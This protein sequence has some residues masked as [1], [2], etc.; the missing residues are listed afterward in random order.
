[1]NR[2]RLGTFVMLVGAL[3]SCAPCTPL[4]SPC[5]RVIVR[6]GDTNAPITSAVASITFADGTSHVL[7]SCAQ[8]GVGLSFGPNCY[9]VLGYGCTGTF[10]LRVRHSSFADFE[11]RVTAPPGRDFE[12]MQN[13]YRVD[14]ALSR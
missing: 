6:D 3:Q 2:F 12:C 13:W 11:Q 10:T 5:L 14:V 9:T 7:G 1:M 4:S 8:S